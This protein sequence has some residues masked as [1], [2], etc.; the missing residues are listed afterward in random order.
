MRRLLALSLTAL[1]AAPATA[2]AA[3]PDDYNPA[4]G[5]Q[6]VTTVPV[7]GAG[8][9][10]IFLDGAADGAGAYAAGRADVN[11]QPSALLVKL[12]PAGQPDPSFS[13]DGVQTDQFDGKFTVA[14][15]VARQADGRPVIAGGDAS[16][17]LFV[18]RY[19]A[20]GTLDP[21]FSGDGYAEL[22]PD[23]ASAAEAT[24][25]GV[26]AAG[27][28][29]AAGVATQSGRKR[30]FVQVFSDAGEP[31]PS[32]YFDFAG[33]GDTAVTDIVVGGTLA[34]IAGETG[35]AHGV[36]RFDTAT[37]APDGGFGTAGLVTVAGSGAHNEIAVGPDGSV[38]L[39][40]SAGLK[41][42]LTRYS[43]AGVADPAL[44]RRLISLY[45]NVTPDF[46]PG[47]ETYDLEL[48]A[49]GSYLVGGITGPFPAN[50]L[51]A[52]IK[53]DGTPD[54]AFAPGGA[55]QYGGVGF[56][57]ALLPQ[58]DGRITVIG[59]G[60]ANGST[61]ITL[62]VL[63][64]GDA[65]IR[66][67][68]HITPGATTPGGALTCEPGEY[69]G[70]AT[71]TAW[72]PR[73]EDPTTGALPD[74]DLVFK[75]FDSDVGKAYRCVVFPRLAGRAYGP[76]T[77]D[78]TGTVL[79]KGADTARRAVR[80]LKRAGRGVVKLTVRLKQAGTITVTGPK[81]F[82]YKKKLGKGK[83]TLRLKPGRKARKLTIALTQGTVT[84]TVT[85]KVRGR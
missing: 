40:S 35:G 75:A 78:N 43:A 18:A 6:G 65:R 49:D 8:N 55:V 41:L 20:A 46:P 83:R 76:V 80:K 26:D 71:F 11:G 47:L 39:A 30:G 13:G 60:G 64:T 48:A 9:L 17:G 52:R 62:Q 5:T 31:G 81:G 25:V 84:T 72:W 37:A 74:P 22:V 42:E 57:S 2:G 34:W 66:R 19:T 10:S 3:F 56:A 53:P 63:G 23:G 12:T 61:P 73:A 21:S 4:Y 59:A 16:E 38:T 24:A 36:A 15:G 50:L 58:A 45:D 7:P 27:R 69:G 67:A 32:R 28:I 77:S 29:V 85:R 1:A 44:D 68:P 82:A 51:L 79:A 54:A 33:Q 70:E 14:Q